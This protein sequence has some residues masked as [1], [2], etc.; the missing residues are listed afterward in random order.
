MCCALGTSRYFE[1]LRYILETIFLD[2]NCTRYDSIEIPEKPELYCHVPTGCLQTLHCNS[3]EISLAYTLVHTS[4][5]STKFTLFKVDMSL[6]FL[7]MSNLLGVCFL[8]MSF[9]MFSS[10]FENLEHLFFII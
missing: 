7:L 8:L 1:R 3:N 10:C 9:G 2:L 6:I 4:R 5:C